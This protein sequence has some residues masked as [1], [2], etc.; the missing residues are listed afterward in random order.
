MFLYWPLDFFIL[1][2]TYSHVLLFFY[3]AVCQQCRRD[4]R[5]TLPSSLQLLSQIYC[6]LVK[7]IW[8]TPIFVSESA[9]QRSHLTYFMS[10]QLIPTE[11]SCKSFSQRLGSILVDKSSY[12]GPSYQVQELHG[13]SSPQTCLSTSLNFN[14]YV[15]TK[16]PIYLQQVSIDKAKAEAATPTTN[17]QGRLCCLGPRASQS[18]RDNGIATFCICSFLPSSC[19]I[20]L[21]Y[22]SPSIYLLF[23]FSFSL[24]VAIIFCFSCFLFF[25]YSVQRRMC[26]KL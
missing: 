1:Q 18:Q 16:E 8:G 4:T 15:I 23:P 20:L 21:C 2:T 9:S 14:K 19:F 5:N 13:T 24:N 25:V 12:L 11:D 26:R 3:Q 7:Y 10:G 22:L 6:L 17:L